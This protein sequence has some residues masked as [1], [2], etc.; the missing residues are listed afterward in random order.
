METFYLVI[1]EDEDAPGELLTDSDAACHTAWSALARQL[2]KHDTATV[3]VQRVVQ[4]AQK[5]DL[6]AK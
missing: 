3:V 4:R 5:K 1:T 2:D 6:G